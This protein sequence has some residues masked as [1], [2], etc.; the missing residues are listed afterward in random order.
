M[1][2]YTFKFKQIVKKIDLGSRL[3]Q[4]KSRSLINAGSLIVLLNM[5]RVMLK[6][7]RD[8]YNRAR[9]LYGKISD[10]GLDST[11]RAQRRSYKKD[12]NLI[13]LHTD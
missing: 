7:L 5:Q 2:S 1:C 8:Y 11:G 13:F 10:R 4:D 9:G 6:I 3:L 12:R